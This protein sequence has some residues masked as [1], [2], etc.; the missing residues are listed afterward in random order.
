MTDQVWVA[1]ID[2]DG[3]GGR[4]GRVV[5]VRSATGRRRDR[6][7]V[8]WRGRWFGPLDAP[9][10]RY[11]Y[12]VLRPRSQADPWTLFLLTRRQRRIL[13]IAPRRD[14]NPEPLALDMEREATRMDGERDALERAMAARL[15]RHGARSMTHHLKTWPEYFQA[16]VD[17]RKMV[18]LR[19][20]DGQLAPGQ[21]AEGDVLVL[22]EWIPPSRDS[23]VLDPGSGPP[24]YTGRVCRR[25]VTHVLRDPE[26]RWLQPGVVA[27]SV[28]KEE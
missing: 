15:H 14:G 27:L 4:W 25:V 28:Q 13:G 17:G 18:E 11:V 6:I 23:F 5:D 10:S 12:R 9:T 8:V 3:T 2:A 26:H 24:G 16:L 7:T 22:E 20:E 21:F 19:I 1:Q